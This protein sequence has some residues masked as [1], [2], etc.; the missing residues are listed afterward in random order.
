MDKQ[1][2]ARLYDRLVDLSQGD[3]GKLMA[4]LAATAS[5]AERQTRYEEKRRGEG[6]QRVPIWVHENELVA[7]RQRY[8]GPR[9]G[10]DW[11]AVVQA[12]LSAPTKAD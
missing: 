1:L 4:H 11:S 10:V 12:A 3:G 8:P 6:F 7:L 2:E 5:S 9:G